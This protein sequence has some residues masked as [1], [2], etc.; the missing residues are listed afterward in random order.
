MAAP[1]KFSFSVRSIL[2]L[3]ERHPKTVPGSSSPFSAARSPLDP[4]TSISAISSSSSSSSSWMLDSDP[5]SCM[6]WDEGSSLEASPDSTKPDEP[7][8]DADPRCAPAGL[9]AAEAA[10]KQKSKKRRVLFSK[11]QTLAL[12]RRFRQ[13]RYLSGP[14]R[15]QVA[16]LLSLTPT[17]VKIWFQNHRYKTK[18]GRGAAHDPQEMQPPPPPAPP[19]PLLRRLLVP[20]LL[21][22]GKP[23]RAASCVLDCS[24]ASPR[25]LRWPL[26]AYPGL[27]GLHPPAAVALPPRHQHL[28]SPAASRVAWADLW[29]DP[30]HFASFK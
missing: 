27:P 7:S 6:S 26:G 24:G 11:A 14:E 30:V 1:T 19:P 4:L 9:T 10:K 15:E 8:P 13:Q 3:P 28:E 17:Q 21:G 12:E 22:D 5:S 2:D 16:R 29:G 23:F 18:R 20:L 25:T